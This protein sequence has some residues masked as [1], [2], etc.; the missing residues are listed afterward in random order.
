MTQAELEELIVTKRR[1]EGTPCTKENFLIWQVKF[2]SEMQ[3]SKES[4]QQENEHSGGYKKSTSNVS[5][6]G[7]GGS[8]NK[9]VDK[10]QRLTG[11][12]Y[13]SDKTNNY[14]AL[15]AA[16]ERAESD[17]NAAT[18]AGNKATED[19]DDD[20]DDIDEELFDDDVDLDDLSFDDEDNDAD[21]DDDDDDDVNI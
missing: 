9:I 14:E 16:A 6:A 21:D 1:A 5:G 18:A 2:D 7:A 11:F 20:D 15:E 8:A 19:D 3:Q 12:Q 10:S 13:F 4:E 17:A